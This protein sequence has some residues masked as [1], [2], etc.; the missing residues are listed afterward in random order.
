MPLIYAKPEKG[1]TALPNSA[2]NARGTHS[3]FARARCRAASF[4]TAQPGFTA[5]GHSR[6]KSKKHQGAPVSRSAL[7]FRGRIL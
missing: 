6:K 4:Y 7:V 5:C 3:S 1:A 2:R